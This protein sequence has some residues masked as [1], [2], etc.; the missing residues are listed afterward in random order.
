[1]TRIDAGLLERIPLSEID[2]V[3]F[4]KHDEITT[5][6]ICCAVEAGGKSW[7]FHEEMA[8]WPLLLEHLEKLPGF[9]A[10]WYAAVYQPAFA[11]CV[12]VAFRR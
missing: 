6:L 12:T 2:T 8:G 7:T 9:R 5:D 11:P 3:T 4:W 1:M 10:D